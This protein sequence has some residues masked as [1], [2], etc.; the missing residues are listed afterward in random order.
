MVKDH[1]SVS[2]RFW[3]G[4]EFSGST[5]DCVDRVSGAASTVEGRKPDPSS[6]EPSAS[7]LGA[8]LQLSGQPRSS[9]LPP[10][11]GSLS[12]RS[13]RWATFGHITGKGVC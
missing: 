7:R 3:E 13:Q 2:F 6:W 12:Q 10:V 8:R 9:S 5:G 4:L 11:T 1:H